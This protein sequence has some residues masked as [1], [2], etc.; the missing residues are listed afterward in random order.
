MADRE[1]T[2]PSYGARLRG[3]ARGLGL[4]G[5]WQWWTAQLAPVMPTSARA[6]LARRRMR[7]VLVFA[8]DHATLW[9]PSVEAGQPVMRTAATIALSPDVNA[10]AAEGQAALTRGRREGGVARVV[11]S[12]APGD[13]LRKRLVVP[14][15][16][17]ENLKQALAYDLDR[18]TPFKAEELDF[19]AVVVERHPARGTITVDLATVRKSVVEPALRHAAAWGAQV[20]AVVP[21]PPDR[22][23]VSR[24]NLLPAE[25]RTAR[26][27]LRR[28]QFWVPAILVFAA[29]V[30][31]IALPLWHKRE[32]VLLLAQQADEARARAAVSETLRSEVN[33][34]VGDYNFALERKF[35][36]PGALAVVNTVSKLLPDDTW[37]TQFE[38]KSIAKGKEVQREI[39]LRG[40]TANAG[41]LVQLFEESQMFAQAA[42]R[43]PTTKIQPGPGEIF[44]LGAQLRQRPA[45]APVALVVGEGAGAPGTAAAPGQVPAPA[46]AQSPS[47]SPP[48]GSAT[49]SAAAS[50]GTSAAAPGGPASPAMAPAPATA[51]AAPATSAVPAANP[52]SPAASPPA[53][54]ANAAASPS[55][56]VPGAGPVP[57]RPGTASAP[58]PAGALVPVPVPAPASPATPGA[59]AASPSGPGGMPPGGNLR[60]EARP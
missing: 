50:P 23:A 59:P 14:A 17:E 12:L 58:A 41:K 2:L 35:A 45:P 31:A 28:W 33:A 22:A 44:D 55:V 29:L 21:E 9:Q 47:A 52:A 43:G 40:E 42:Q 25:A 38:I 15:A 20:V 56:P 36:F 60:R 16:L 34:K 3:A 11:I 53:A 24:L 37:I 1:L 19:D 30:A 51:P 57:A 46:P 10:H 26:P 6:A 5:F 54:G 49:P 4:A 39:M 7:P 27:L 32:Q 48:P 13:V 18:H 8:S